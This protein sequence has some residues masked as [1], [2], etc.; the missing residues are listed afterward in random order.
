[1]K[2]VSFSLEQ[3]NKYFG[4]IDG[5]RF[6]IGSRVPYEGR[7][8]LMNTTGSGAQKYERSKYRPEYGFWADFIY[9]TAVAEGALFHTLNSYDSARFTF[10][11]LQ[12]AAHV[13]NGDFVQ[14]L[15]ALLKLPLGPEY[16]PDLV[17]KDGRINRVMDDGLT[18]L[19]TDDSTSLLMDYLNPSSFE[20]EDTEIIQ[21]AKFIRWAQTDA[22]HRKVQLDVGI[23]LFKAKMARY[24]T[25]Y[26]LDGAQDA[27]CSVIADIRHQGRSKSGPILAGLQG[28]D[29]LGSLLKI[30]ENRYPARITALRREIKALLKDGTFGARKYSVARGDFVQ[31]A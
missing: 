9:P 18:V 5:A 16:F 4:K 27:V 19:E 17:I 2:L 25:Q 14:Y 7:K 15:R 6:F 3:G 21:S 13:P 31:P 10:S 1:M 29:P 12:F 23:A 26:Q 8:G 30:G 28:P 20:I 22:A 24:A 11:F